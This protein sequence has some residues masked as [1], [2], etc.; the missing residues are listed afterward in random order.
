MLS[1]CSGGDGGSKA[2]AHEVFEFSG[3][4]AT[5]DGADI[6][7]QVI[8]DQIAA[9]RQAPEA[10]QTALHVDQLLQ[11]GSDQP[12]PAVVAD[13]LGTEISVRA[14][15]AELAKRA[16]TVSD[17]DRDV[18]SVQVKAS[19]GSSADKL[20][21]AFVQQTIDRYASFVALDQALAIQPTEDEMHA[22]YDQHPDEYQRACVRHIL[23]ATEADANDVLAQLRGGADF[24]T[25]AAARTT[26]QEGKADG[27]DL[28][29]VP[30]GS[31]TDDFEKA[32]WEAP[33]GELSGP[34]QL[35]V[36]LP[37]PPGDQARP[38]QLDDVKEDIKA[39]IGPAPFQ[40]LGIWRQVNLA[41]ADVTVD[42]RFGVWDGLTGQVM[43]RG[44]RHPGPDVDTEHRRRLGRRQLR[45]DHHDAD[46]R[47]PARPRRR[48]RPAE[49]VAAGEGVPATPAGKG[50]A[51]RPETAGHRDRHGSGPRRAFD[52]RP[53]VLGGRGTRRPLRPHPPPSDGGR[54]RR[55]R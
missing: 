46:D 27:G 55:L 32:V 3:T 4:A 12:A 49:P 1:A 6:P 40:S 26:D 23:V 52:G 15:E 48:P 44:H 16:I 35:R 42:P 29:C 34:V 47:G 2:A 31:F 30:K 33:V 43:P 13:L 21:P 38:G 22:Q 14:I 8:D 50:R 39:E 7:A 36:R 51:G 45:V 5:L 53:A 20:P 10:A 54:P 17:A 9:F 18:A 25:V 37:R 11:D 19:F 41:R 28:G 24:A